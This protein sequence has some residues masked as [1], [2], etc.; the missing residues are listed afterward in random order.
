[1]AKLAE[2]EGQAGQD[3]IEKQDKD[4]AAFKQRILELEAAVKDAKALSDSQAARLQEL[5]AE[6]S[7]RGAEK[8]RL[9][10]VIARME[11]EYNHK[12]DGLQKDLDVTAA[13][14]KVS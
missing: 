11:T 12:L 13:K 6:H 7:S 9:E 2:I 10:G 3:Y 4:F 8:D 1:M 5:E 14:L